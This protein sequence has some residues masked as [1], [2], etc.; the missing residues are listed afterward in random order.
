MPKI[1]PH[2]KKPIVKRDTPK[3]EIPKKIKRASKPI[4]KPKRVVPKKV[5]PKKVVPKKAVPKKV[6]PKKVVPKKAVPKKVIPKK[7]APKKKIP[8]KVTPKPPKKEAPTKKV[9]KK[10][11]KDLFSSIKTKQPVKK[12]PKNTQ[13]PKQPR[14][15]REPSSIKHNMSITDRIKATHQ[16]GH[17]SNAN[18]DK[19]IENAYIARVKRHMNNW[20]P[21]GMK[22]QWV[23]VNLTIYNSGKFRYTTSGVSGAMRESLKRYLDTLNRMGLGRHK[24]STP[25]SIQVRFKVR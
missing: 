3:K 5:V 10:T 19:G 16:S 8:K 2:I 1:I 22:G 13:P 12:R 21:V 18:R 24:K 23:T 6:V 25:Y 7:I 15:E 14:V 20:N 17:I 11:A 9:P 4:P